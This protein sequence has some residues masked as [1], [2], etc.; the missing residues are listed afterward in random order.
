MESVFRISPLAMSLVKPPDP[1][2]LKGL[3]LNA[4]RELIAQHA[5]ACLSQQ[6]S[7]AN[8]RP[9]SQAGSR[10]GS[11]EEH[12]QSKLETNGIVLLKNLFFRNLYFSLQN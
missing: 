9:G 8:S 11:F 10:R 4:Q 6:G 7:R 1:E 5:E 3:P 12:E 2:I